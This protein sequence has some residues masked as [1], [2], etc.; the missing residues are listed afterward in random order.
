MNGA[1]FAWTATLFPACFFS[2]SYNQPT[3]GESGECPAGLVC[4]S[5]RLCETSGIP[6]NSDATGYTMPPPPARSCL[7]LAMT[8][9]VSGNDD[10]CKSLKVSGGTF[11][12]SN[13]RAGAGDLRSPAMIG[14]FWL[15]RYE[16]TVGRFRAFVEA[17][18]GTQVNSPIAGQGAHANFPAS[19]WDDRWNAVLEANRAALVAAV[20]CDAA[21]HTWTDTIQSTDNRPM[22]CITWYEAMAF[23]A[24]DG[25][26]LPTEAEWNYAAAG[27]DEQRAYPWSN[28]P[29]VT[30]LDGTHSS[31]LEGTNCVGDGMTGCQTSDLIAVGTKPAGDGRWDHSD[32]AGNVSEWTLDWYSEYAASCANCAKIVSSSA[33]RVFRGGGFNSGANV[34]RSGFRDYNTPA[35][36]ADFIGMRC[37]RPPSP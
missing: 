5:E 23:C 4:N 21:F 3:C 30:A 25:G 32:L 22:N 33:V 7:Q 15:D 6:M 27:G 36:R 29:E 31:Y 35:T 34:L 28:P 9:G 13:D 24:W 37:A 14:T 8:C 2:P 17:G 1:R 12:R 19:G 11:F 18:M 10:C 26:F 16:V 20:K